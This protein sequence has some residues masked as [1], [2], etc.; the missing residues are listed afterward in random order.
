MSSNY[1]RWDLI[2]KKYPL[3]EL[4]WELGRPRDILVEYMNKEMIRPGKALDIC[5]GAGTNTIYL[6][7]KGFEVNG[8]DIS[9]TAL[10]IAKEKAQKQNVNVSFSIQSFVNLAFKDELFDFIFDMGCF[11]HVVP[12]DRETF[13][14]GT[15]RTLKNN[16]TLM[17]TAF[18]QKNGSAWNHFTKTQL[19]ELFSD[20]F[21]ITNIRHLSSIE[22]DGYTRH[23]YTLL[24]KKK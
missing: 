11:H 22:G 15:Y 24:M 23:F 20:H 3:N 7:Q 17:L 12:K 18:S 5:C 6:A 4:G 8:I 2:Y 19:T 1:K 21:S 13:I 10:K 14:K 16:G 9:K